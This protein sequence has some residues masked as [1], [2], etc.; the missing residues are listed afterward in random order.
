MLKFDVMF[1]IDVWN[2]KLYAAIVYSRWILFLGVADRPR[3]GEGLA[4]I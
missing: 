3:K 4:S 1:G 2:F